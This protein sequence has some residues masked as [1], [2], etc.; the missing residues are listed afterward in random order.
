MK[1]STSDLEGFAEWSGDRN[2]L[3][4]DQEFAGQTS[5]GH[6]ITHG[7]LAV[8]EA[9]RQG[10]EH[11]KE[12][13]ENFEVEFQGAV[14]PDVLYDVQSS[15]GQDQLSLSVRDGLRIVLK[16]KANYGNG[17]TPSPVPDF[18]W[19]LDLEETAGL[20]SHQKR[21]FPA[22]RTVSDLQ[23][24]LELTGVYAT[25]SPPT[26]YVE[27]SSLKL[28]EL[29]VLGLCSYL[30]GMEVPGQKSLFTRLRLSFNQVK[31]DSSRLIYQLRTLRFDKEFRILD[32]VLH[33]ATLNGECVATGEIRSYV[34]FSPTDINLGQLQTQLN[35]KLDNLKGKVAL[36]CG[37]SRGLG[38]DLSACLAL[39]GCHVY[40]SYRKPSL[41]VNE[42]QEKLAAQNFHLNFLPGD[43]GDL[44][45]CSST[46]ETIKKN[47]DR[48]DLV[49]LNACSPPTAMSILT[50]SV[51]EFEQ[52]IGDNLKLV[53]NPLAKFL[54]ILSENH[55]AILPISS[56][57]VEEIPPGFGHYVALKQ[58]VE[59]L[60]KSASKEFS[61]IY[62][63]I[64]RPPRL[65]TSWNDT[66]T[67]VL[68]ALPTDTVASFIVNHVNEKWNSP[69]VDLLSDFTQPYS[70]DTNE[71]EASDPD[72]NL[73]IAGSFT[74]ESLLPG[75]RF[76]FAELGL[77]TR[78]E[79]TPYGQV[80]QGLLNPASLLSSTTK[81]ISVVLL[82]IQDW[83]REL[84]IE[85]TQSLEKT[86]SYLSDTSKEF[87][88][89]IR[90]HR[91]H[92]V[93][94]T[95]LV[96]CP[97]F[98][99]LTTEKDA[100]IT[101]VETHLYEELHAI[102]GL[103]VISAQSFH[104]MYDV[105][106][107]KIEDPLRN[108]IAHVPYQDGYFHVLSTIIVRKVHRKT[109]LPR[110]VI[111][112]DCDN[113][114]WKGVVG[115]VG[116]Q[117]IDFTPVHSRFH[118]IL[119][120]L[121]QR[122]ILIALCSKNEEE[123]VWEV[124]E[125]RED[126]GLKR[127]SIVASMINWNPKSH[128]IHVLASRLNLGLE[129]F[130]FIDDNP[131]E[132]AEVRAGC[133]EVLVL[134]WPQ[135][136]ENARKLLE[137]TWEL[138][139]SDGTKEDQKRTQL[140]REEF[141]RQ[142][143]Q[144]QALSF[145]DFIDNLNLNVD[146]VPLNQEDLLR[147]SQLTLRTNQ[148]NFTTRRRNEN[149]LQQL[150]ADEK[151]VCQ[152]VRVSDRFG[153]YGLV[154]FFIIQKEG[155]G[156]VVD[157]FLLSCRVLGR[158]VEHHMAAE[159][160]RLAL[161]MGLKDVHFQVT[162]TKR[163][164][165]ARNFLESI[166]EG[167]NKSSGEDLL[168]SQL[169]AE[170][171]A[172][173]RF[174]PMRH[175]GNSS[176]QKRTSEEA[177][178][179]KINDGDNLRIRERQIFK[180]S[181]ELSTIHGLLSAID[182]KAKTGNLSP[183]LSVSKNA[184]ED[185]CEK[186]YL[187]FSNSL[188]IP[189]E[190]LK[191]VDQLEALGCS[192]FKIVEITVTLTAQF[193]WLP[194]TLL[195][196]HRSISEIIGKITELLETDTDE[197][198]SRHFKIKASDSSDEAGGYGTT[199][200]DIAVVG[201]SVRCAGANSMTELWEL[202]HSGG[203]SVARVPAERSPSNSRPHWACL[204]SKDTI[205]SFDAEFFGISPREAE[206]MDPQLRLILEVAWEAL[207]DAGCAQPEHETGVYI[208]AMYEDYVF[209]ANRLANTPDSPYR[210]WESFSLANR[211]SQVL[212]LGGPSFAINTACSSAGVAIHLACRSL[213][214]G[215]CKTAIVGGVNLV[216][217]PNRLAQLDRLGIL[218]TT[219]KCRSFGAD[220]DGTIV[221]EGVG[222]VVLKPLSEAQRCGDRIY[223]VIKGTALSTG[224]G[225]VGFTAPNPQAQADA[226]RR[227]V[228]NSGID[229]RTISYVEAHGT[230]TLL[231]DPIEVRGLTLAYTD[232]KLWDNQ[233]RGQYAHKIASIKPNIGHLEAGAG[234]LGLIKVLLQFKHK[235]LVPSLHSVQTNPQISFEGSPFKV[236]QNLEPWERPI[237]KFKDR[238][239]YFPRRAG[240]SSFGVGGA[241]VHL[242]LEEPS[243]TSLPDNLLFERPF[244]IL[245]LS[246]RN[247]ES[248]NNQALRFQ[249]FLGSNQDLTLEDISYTANIGRKHFDHRLA[250]FGSNQARLVGSLEDY[251][252]GEEPVGCV[253]GTRP[254]STGPSKIAFLFTGQ[255]AQYLDMGKALYNTHPVFRET[256]DQC[257]EILK[258]CMNCSIL[259]VMFAERESSDA[260]LLN[261]TGYTQPALF[262]IEYS[263]SK[264]WESWGIHPGIVIGHSVGEIAA[265][266]VAG[267][268]SLEDG[269]KLT[270]ARGQLMQALP[271]G[272]RMASVRA[273]EAEVMKAILAYGDRVSI[274]GFNSPEQTVI[275]GDGD[276][277]DEILAQLEVGGIK[278]KALSV[279]HAFHSH[280]M[281]PMIDEFKEVVKGINF[282]LPKIPFVSCVKGTLV[283][284]E[285]KDSEYWV[286][287][288]RN[289][290]RFTEGMKRLQEQ[291]VTTFLEV[292]P[293]PVL[294]GMGKHCLPDEEADWLPSLRGGGR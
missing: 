262:V 69:K 230:G 14:S 289:P 118:G 292:G 64:A 131:V 288:V 142:E 210:C 286:Q 9:F 167:N 146:I 254:Q 290:V 127:D 207:E 236:Q 176:D 279:S 116:A 57:F 282:S 179:T 114:L 234:V 158:G 270:A 218:S 171:L 73:V 200:G 175:A 278:T 95:F 136:S 178:S 120:D 129:S 174:D 227:S 267:G 225:T 16:A 107:K 268:V 275:S 261:Q 76:W 172:T 277:I 90:T 253:Q 194:S 13:V 159:I 247:K 155:H 89:A 26:S 209:R 54:P 27:G 182:G 186:V 101:R 61:N 244:H 128:N 60:V 243:E 19:A 4:L 47:H 150:L 31:D 208:G 257:V 245:T 2:P 190:E 117:G 55:G 149:E 36:V 49:V 135:N 251:A 92:T 7:I 173:L 94:E 113:T 133:P 232:R 126:F 196:E 21:F 32:A 294:L 238:E 77:R 82:C 62:C 86:E 20:S 1:F 30:V 139:S 74:V 63:L 153:D 33:V 157:T 198:N 215:E 165:P 160:G 156:F 184:P 166:S 38:A 125:K 56:S 191:K 52:Y 248:L 193:P 40:V 58:A 222:V 111:V 255:G 15:F 112:L 22:I 59:G 168:E 39:A 183:N 18:S 71:P 100:Q 240:L 93:V 123:D 258:S 144:D 152:T 285:I 241:N 228:R 272:G 34:P 140:Y 265:L 180:T 5:F 25:D 96:I 141:E 162:T 79:I 163:N 51:K 170:S 45:W 99:S 264:L 256:L 250:I 203:S 148:F 122:G 137:H 108:E 68:G 177:I 283:T 12:S 67:G 185:V 249:K 199:T 91:A 281:D 287:Q 48:L 66:P 252:A 8:I 233:I 293:Q 3:H 224:T 205:E 70:R 17:E 43:A 280:L 164:A 78:V 35:P 50:H 83:L 187:A 138:D 102:P 109:I 106:A 291:S 29:R 219:G 98:A 115:E 80:L 212:G 81:G 104:S 195:F 143:L 88:Q 46:L 87:I 284:D 202:L 188:E 75:L 147:S 217:D 105:D 273:G 130:I 276:A 242:I 28:L 235:L 204:L 229:P 214:A 263:L 271:S 201:L 72:L 197:E 259:D 119:T 37:G 44:E 206:Y 24:G 211:L 169:S 161:E 97:S 189:L 216:L 221:G 10:G 6:P 266:C 65:Q 220:A 192:S 84:P 121:S 42:L 41:L 151:Y 223:G 260:S 85:V 269:L 132:C 145:G 53:Q 237:L 213:I 124:F 181:L 11:S 246:A 23:K 103:Q 134:E 110:K 154:G 231:G 239:K 226:I 274:A